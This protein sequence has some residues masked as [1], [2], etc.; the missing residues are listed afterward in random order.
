MSAHSVPAVHSL[1]RLGSP[2]ALDWEMDSPAWAAESL[3]RAPFVVMRRLLPR[4]SGLPVGVRGAARSQRAAAWVPA[5]AVQ[6]CITPQMLAA[7]Q[8]WRQRRDFD[9]MPAVAALEDVAAIFDGHGMSGRWGPGGSVGFE[10][11]SGVPATTPDSDLDIVLDAAVSMARLDAARLHAELSALPVRIDVLLE[12]PNG[13]V[14]LAEYAQSAGAI[15]LRS[16][17]GPRLSRD[18]W[19]AHLEACQA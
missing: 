5:G 7:Q 4:T 10:L 17:Q 11:A 14:A 12:T 6:E 1:F 13:A 19:R 9:I 2:D 15:L 3:R 8:A 16:P 18:P